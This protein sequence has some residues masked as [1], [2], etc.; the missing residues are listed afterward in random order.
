MAH[1]F[2]IFFL[3]HYMDIIYKQ[4]RNF[5]TVLQTITLEDVKKA[6]GRAEKIRK[7]N[8][9]NFHKEIYKKKYVYYKDNPDCSLQ[10]AVKTVLTECGL[11]E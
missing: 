1:F 4:E 5:Q 2:L 10:E 3:H 11:M 7:Y 9:Q 6:I 8:E